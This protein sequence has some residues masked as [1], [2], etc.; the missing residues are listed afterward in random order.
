M[1]RTSQSFALWGNYSPT[2]PYYL[3]YTSSFG[4]FLYTTCT[5][6]ELEPPSQNLHR[7][8]SSSC[9][10]GGDEVSAEGWTCR[11]PA[12]RHL[13]A[14]R[15]HCKWHNLRH[16]RGAA[17][18]SLVPERRWCP[19]KWWVPFQGGTISGETRRKGVIFFLV[20]V[21]ESPNGALHKTCVLRG[22]RIYTPRKILRI[23]RGGPGF[24]DYRV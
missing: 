13:F 2:P 20:W 4:A 15:A 7:G 16:R 21:T 19:P 6:S 10:F 8:E 14:K 17:T 18:P 22:P 9:K 1:N 24:I 5:C 12:M 23:F 11:T 3:R